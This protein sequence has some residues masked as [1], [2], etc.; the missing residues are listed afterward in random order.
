MKEAT[1]REKVLGSIRNALIHASD[2]PWVDVEM[3]SSIHALIDN[4]A[5]IT[6]ATGFTATGGKFVYCEDED[7]FLQLLYKLLKEKG[8]LTPYLPEN[9]L[10]DLLTDARIPFTTD[11]PADQKMLISKCQGLLASRAAIISNDV[12]VVYENFETL[13]Y[14]ADAG[15]LFA[16][17]KEY[18]KSKAARP[19]ELISSFLLINNSI[20]AKNNA[21]QAEVEKY[22]VFYIDKL[23]L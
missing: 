5:A 20:S 2:N 8:V 12:S 9:S 14:V 4:D 11:V 10:S 22:Y 7:V 16:D 23:A 19:E 6:F 1:S 17:I 21:T 15:M 3:E 13:V 18:A